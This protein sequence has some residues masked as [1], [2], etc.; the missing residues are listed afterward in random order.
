MRFR[1]RS[2][3]ANMYISVRLATKS[4]DFSILVLYKILYVHA[5]TAENWERWIWFERILY[6]NRYN[7]IH[8]CFPLLEKSIMYQTCMLL[9][10]LNIMFKKTCFHYYVC[11]IPITNEIHHRI[12]YINSNTIC[13]NH[14]YHCF[15]TL[16][17]EVT[18]ATRVLLAIFTQEEFFFFLFSFGD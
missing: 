16:Q 5:S 15:N 17:F 12:I 18:I 14:A 11:G 3:L 4:I 1:R 13:V 2:I 7:T 10:S 6:I 8:I 9:H